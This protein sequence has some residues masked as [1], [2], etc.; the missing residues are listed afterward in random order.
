MNRF[1]LMTAFAA[2]VALAGCT[3]AEQ[4]DESDAYRAPVYRT[5]SNLPAGRETGEAPKELSPAERRTIEDLQNRPRV[6][7][8]P[9]TK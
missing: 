9:V 8:G 7:S 6:P 5:G 2:W 1:T 3:G 4:K